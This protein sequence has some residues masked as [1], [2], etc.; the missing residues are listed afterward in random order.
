MNKILIVDD[1]LSIRESFSLILGDKYKLLLAASGEA[2]LKHAASQQIDLA[3]L[4]IRMPGLNGLETLRRLKEIDPQIEVIMV[5]AVNEVQKASEAIKH[6]ARD[7]IIKPFD[8]EAIQKMTENLLRRK[9]QVA[10][11]EELKKESKK[12]SLKLIGQSEKIE[13]VSA[14][15]N[16]IAPKNLRTMIV[17]ETGTEK[18]VVAAIIHA[19]SARAGLPFLTYSLTT[20]LSPGEIKNRLLGWEKGSTTADL[21]KRSGLIEEARGGTLF[22]DHA[23]FLTFDLPPADARLIGGSKESVE[24]FAE[25]LISLPPLRER[26]SDLPLLINYYLEKYSLEF[27]REVSEVAP[28]VEEIFSNYSWPGNVAELKALLKRLVLNSAGEWLSAD[29]LPVDFLLKT[30]SARGGNYFAQ[31]EKE[32]VRRILDETGGDQ[33]R[34]AAILA[35]SPAVLEGKI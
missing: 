9:S 28:E 6:G 23:E 27:A 26:L 32:Y 2:A 10:E 1:E 7:Y 16:K 21:K 35:V 25:V 30:S 24:F 15:I 22:I 31:F 8:V 19:R 17:G 34:A 3:Y 5:T 13:E 20:Q 11:S 4:D 12:E 18:E 29:D 14:L 33:A